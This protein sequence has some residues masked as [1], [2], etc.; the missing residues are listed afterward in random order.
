[1]VQILQR[2]TGYVLRPVFRQTSAVRLESSSLDNSLV[3]I[4]YRLHLLNL[5]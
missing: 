2:L 1:M 3:S 5:Q 4:V